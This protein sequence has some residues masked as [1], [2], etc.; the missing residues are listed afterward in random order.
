MAK[1]TEWRVICHDDFDAWFTEQSE[2][3]QDAIFLF[4]GCKAGDD[5][6]YRKS[7]PIAD[8]RFRGHLE[9]LKRKK[10]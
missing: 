1:K 9:E 4:G 8:A 7:V 3:L 5:R 2:D 10:G 6:W